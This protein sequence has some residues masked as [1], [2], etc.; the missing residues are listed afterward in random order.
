MTGT[1]PDAEQALENATLA[2][3]AEHMLN[4]RGRA[5]R[6][7]E[8]TTTAAQIL[9]TARLDGGTWRRGPWDFYEEGALLWLE[10]DTIIRERTDGECS[11]DDFCRRFCGGA[12]GPAR[13]ARTWPSR[14]PGGAHEPAAS[15][16]AASRWGQ[17]RSTRR[18]PWRR[19]TPWAQRPPAAA[20]DRPGPA[21]RAGAPDA[22]GCIRG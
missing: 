7:L 11:L 19:T 15:G 6:P 5:W 21:R 14:R 22:G 3:F 10:A 17:A 1:H 4:T 8:D 20:R 16:R 12:G 18:A 9:Y 2:L 13:V